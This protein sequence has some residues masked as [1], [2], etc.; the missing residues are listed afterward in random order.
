MTYIEVIK[1]QRKSN[2]DKVAKETSERNI[3]SEIYN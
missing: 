2:K 3:I 1:T